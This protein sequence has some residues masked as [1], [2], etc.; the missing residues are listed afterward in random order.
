VEIVSLRLGIRRK[1]DAL[2]EIVERPI[3]LH[4]PTE[5][6]IRTGDRTVHARLLTAASLLADDIV[7]GPALLES[8]SS[9][10]WVP[11]SWHAT[12]DAGGNVLLRRTP[13]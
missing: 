13:S 3:M 9:T 10:T 2:P 1:L 6:P 11:P 5:A 12:R 8:Y 7:A 4:G